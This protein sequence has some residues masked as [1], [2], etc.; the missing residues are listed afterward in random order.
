MNSL[1]STF[2]TAD[3]VL[4]AMTSVIDPELGLN[5]VDLGLIRGVHIEPDGRLAVTMTLTNPGCPLQAT[6]T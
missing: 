2:I 1:V 3:F 5:I 4:A 6:F